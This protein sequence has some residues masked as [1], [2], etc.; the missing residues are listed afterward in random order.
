MNAMV[1]MTNEIK[2][3]HEQLQQ[4]NADMYSIVA[5]VVLLENRI[6]KLQQEVAKLKQAKK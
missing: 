1:M 3:N 2:K 5:K 6:K 4:A